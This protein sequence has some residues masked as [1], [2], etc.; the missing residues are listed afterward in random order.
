MSS[1]TLLYDQ[2]CGFCRWSVDKILAWDR[3]GRIRAV[4]L[5]SD[6]ADGLLHDVDPRMRMDS[7]HLVSAEGRVYSAGAL[8]DPLLRLLT[9][10]RPFAVIAGA[11]PGTT[12]RAYRLVARNR[13]RLGRLLG[14]SACAVDPEA[15]RRR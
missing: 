10:G 12:E 3:H 1:A 15:S 4:S 13:H 11:L 8:V 7:A 2:D 6:E 5:R 9:G 14:T